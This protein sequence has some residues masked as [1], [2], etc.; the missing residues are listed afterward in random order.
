MVLYKYSNEELADAVSSN[1]SVMAVMRALGIRMVG[2]SH[3]HL[4]KRIEALGLDTAHFTR[5]AHNKG[6]VSPRRQPASEILT[7]KDTDARR[8]STHRLNRALREIGREYVCQQCLNQGV[9]NGKP[10]VLEVDHINGSSW[11]DR[12]ENLRWLCPN[13][14][15]Q[16]GTT[17]PWKY[18]NY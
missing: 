8:T 11:D 2:G 4:S 7:L 6:K 5:Q 14:H 12:P 15:S 9:Y 18:V 1:V 17:K 13:C 16:Q 10:L 3:T